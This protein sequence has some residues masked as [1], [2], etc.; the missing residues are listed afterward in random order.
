MES[1][2]DRP[3]VRHAA[4]GRIDEANQKHVDMRGKHDNPFFPAG[5]RT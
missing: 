4:A 3:G 2:V 5:F 1:S